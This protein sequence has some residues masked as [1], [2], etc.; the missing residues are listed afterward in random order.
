MVATFIGARSSH[1]LIPSRLWDAPLTL[2]LITR[3]E[4][5]M[6]LLLLILGGSY[7]TRGRR[8]TPSSPVR[9]KRGPAG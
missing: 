5:T 9:A 7:P 3:K 8:D 4:Q 6:A 1:T 2:K